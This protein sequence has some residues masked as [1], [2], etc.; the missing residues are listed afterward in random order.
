MG[1]L[2]AVQQSCI[3]FLGQHSLIYNS[4]ADSPRRTA[5][6]LQG[7]NISSLYR[8]PCVC[9]KRSNIGPADYWS[10]TLPFTVIDLA[11]P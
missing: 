8:F 3:A 7:K 9:G 4:A 10:L 2:F 6:R 1:N 5:V 11:N